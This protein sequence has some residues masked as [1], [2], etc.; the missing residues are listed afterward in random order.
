[1]MK[2]LMGYIQQYRKYFILAPLLVVGESLAELLLPYLMGLIVDNGVAEKDVPYMFT[3]GG[4]MVLVAALGIVDGIF[5]AKFSA[6]ASQGFGYNLRQAIFKKVQTF[7]F[8]DVDKFSTAS[9][10]TRCTTDVKQL[11]Q[12][13]M[14]LTRVLI[15]A[16]SLLIISLVICIRMNWKL[17]ITFLVAIPTLLAVVLIIMKFTTYLFEVM[18]N[19]IDN[20]NASVQENLIAIRVVKSFVRMGHEKLKFKKANDD[21]MKTSISATIRLSVMEPATR[22]VLYGTTL[23]IYWFGGKMVGTG[24]LQSGELLSFV[25]YINNILMSVMMCSMV[26]MG[27]TRARACGNR[28]V[29]VLN[30]EPDIKDGSEG[31]NST[32][33]DTPIRGEIRFDHVSF[34]YPQTDRRDMVLDDVSFTIPAGSFVAI[35]GATGVGKTSMVSLIPRFYDVTSGN[36]YVDGVNVKD[37]NLRHL[38]SHIGMVLQ[39]NVLFTGTIRSN[40]QWGAPGG[41]DETLLAATKDSQAYEFISRFPEGLDTEIEQGGVNVSGGQKQRLCIA[42]AMLK[43]PSILILDD[44]TSAVDSGTEA[45]IRETFY[46][47][48]KDTTV[49]LVAQRISSVQYADQ[50][51]VLDEGKLSD[52][53]THDE[54]MARSKVYQAIYASQQEG[55]GLDG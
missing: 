20:L 8:A 7:S 31:E 1:M 17:S 4:I 23:A 48:Y 3:I 5:A 22:M 9:L 36:V 39:S 2:Q 53:G 52:M 11:Q 44:S 51:I 45:K 43:N 15:R 55:G 6:K 29:E 25:T 21:L 37:Y 26:L 49:L 16:P 10:V 35:V 47:K 40:L 14:E 28:V 19:K 41:D 54:L 32:V 30:H 38:R 12:T 18:Q 13:A 50:I 27:M 46:S 24:Q 33:E 42:R 34:R